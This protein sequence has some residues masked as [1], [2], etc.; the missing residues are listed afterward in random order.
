MLIA[1]VLNLFLCKLMS[2]KKSL[3]RSSHSVWDESTLSGHHEP[4]FITTSWWHEAPDISW[5][6]QL[7]KYHQSE[8]LMTRRKYYQRQQQR[9]EKEEQLSVHQ[10]ECW[11]AWMAWETDTKKVD[12]EKEIEKCVT[13]RWRSASYAKNRVRRRLWQRSSESYQRIGESQNTFFI[14][15]F[16]AHVL[17]LCSFSFFFHRWIV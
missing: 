17:S 6:L 11:L 7:K 1:I 16:L 12:A 10:S 2:Q 14:A 4:L 13:W 15:R 3:S 8:K 9:K 5:L